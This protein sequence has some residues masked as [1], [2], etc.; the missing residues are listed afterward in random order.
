MDKY[1]VLIADD[2]EIIR[3]G[4]RSL[5]ETDEDFMVVAMAE[6]GEVALNLARE[7]KPDLI[8]ADINMPFMNGLDFVEEL[9]KDLPGVTVVI[10][11]GYDDFTYVR[12][13]LQLGAKDYILKP[14]MEEPFYELLNKMKRVIASKFES[15]K[16][17]KWAKGQIEKNRL[18]LIDKFMNEWIYTN[19]DEIEVRE[20]MQYLGI[21]LPES[22]MLTLINMKESIDSKLSEELLNFAAKNIAEEV[23]ESAILSFTSRK[24]VLAVLS[25]DIEDDK[26][27]ELTD[28]LKETFER[29]LNVRAEIAWERGRSFYEMSE[30]FL[31]LENS[32]RERT[33]YSTIVKESIAL[34]ER[35]YMEKELSL[36]SASDYLHISPQYLSR[37]FKAETGETFGSFLADFRAKK[38]IILLKDQELKIY[39]IA[40]RCGYATQHYFSNAFKKETGMSPM[41]YRAQICN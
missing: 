2:E 19:P 28:K 22:F 23:I 39:E 30:V 25:A 8:L 18:A 5:V 9:L 21:N 26:I 24:G 40:E 1:K 29:I 4:L 34:I 12:K 11:T 32:L 3:S 33:E 27:A 38:A 31:N 41:D 6:D 10:V 14:I 16:Y 17:I 36:Q 15:G 37:L 7:Y 35:E 13:A 20:K